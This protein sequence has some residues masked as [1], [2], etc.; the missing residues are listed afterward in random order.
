[1]WPIEKCVIV[2]NELGCVSLRAQKNLGSI[3][4]THGQT[5]SLE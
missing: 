4:E 5:Q 1:M 3:N 2:W